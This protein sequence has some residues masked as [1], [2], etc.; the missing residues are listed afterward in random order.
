MRLSSGLLVGSAVAGLLSIAA[1]LLAMPAASLQ[2]TLVMLL[3]LLGYVLLERGARRVRWPVAVGIGLLAAVAATRLLWWREQADEAGWLTYGQGV[4]TMAMSEPAREMIDRERL[5]ALGLLLGVVCLAAGAL[6]L[7][8][9]GRRR[10]AVTSVLALTLLTWLGLSLGRGS[11]RQPLLDL[12]ATVWPALLAAVVAIGAFALSGWRADRHWLLPL[13]LFL[14]SVAAAHACSELAT[15]WSDWVIATG[16]PS[17]AFLKPGMRVNTSADN[18]P[19]VSWAVSAAITLAGVGM[20]A[21]GA[22]R[23]SREADAA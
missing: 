8:S 3:A 2:F 11:D 6:A 15:A 21:V 17:D 10:G 14:L 19:Q 13:G 5:A 20:V 1:A 16:P 18:F 23:S 9:R 7:P 12:A 22:S 4:A